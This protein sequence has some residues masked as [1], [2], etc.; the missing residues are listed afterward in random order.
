MASTSTPTSTNLKLL[1]PFDKRI[2]LSRVMD[3][4]DL[5]LTAIR[6]GQNPTDPKVCSGIKHL[7]GQLS[8]FLSQD[9]IIPVNWFDE[10][11]DLHDE[12]ERFLNPRP[13]TPD[14]PVTVEDDGEDLLEDRLE[15]HEDSPSYP[16]NTTVRRSNRGWVPSTKYGPHTYVL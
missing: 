9:A 13:P 3:A 10:V 16:T 11:W 1:T 14:C 4:L 15:D 5:A 12:A 7:Y 8:A 2:L 6:E